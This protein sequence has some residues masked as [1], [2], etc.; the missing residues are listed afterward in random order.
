MNQQM[1]IMIVIS[2]ALLWL[3]ACAP[4]SDGPA[5]ETEEPVGLPNP[6][7]VYCEE[8]GGQLEMRSDANGTH[9]VCIFD[10]G[11]E[12]EEWAYYRGE[13]APGGADPSDQESGQ[14]DVGLANPAA[15]YCQEQGYQLE[16]HTDDSGTHSVCIFDDG[17]ECEQWAYWRGECGPSSND[18][19]VNVA[20]EAKLV[21]TIK[22][23][24][25]ELD[26]SGE[27]GEPYRPLLTIEDEFQL[28]DITRSLNTA[29]PRTP[30][31]FCIPTLQLRFHLA[32]GT[33]QELGYMCD[34]SQPTLTGEQSYWQNQEAAAPALFVALIESHRGG[35]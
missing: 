34:P 12:C 27:S 25:L 19:R 15:V 5:A 33:V 10:D 1:R 4:T 16:S 3:A 18:Q 20:L 8:Q 32:D 23:E 22:L 6:A 31:T 13:C 26:S 24:L 35:D 2:L 28:D 30:K 21:Q 14:V 11:S 29:A 7:S 9:G 17:S